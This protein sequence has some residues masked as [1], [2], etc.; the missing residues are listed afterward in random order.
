MLQIKDD[1]V[2]APIGPL[3]RFYDE[4]ECHLLQD[5]H[6]IYKCDRVRHRF[7]LVLEFLPSQ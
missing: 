5:E 7:L 2:E 3:E 4:N 1:E 6:A